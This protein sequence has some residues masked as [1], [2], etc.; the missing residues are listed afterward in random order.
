MGSEEA[1]ILRDLKRAISEYVGLGVAFTLVLGD[2]TLQAELDDRSLLE[3]GL[4]EG[5]TLVVLMQQRIHVVTASDGTTA[6]SG[7]QPPSSWDRRNLIMGG[8]Q[9]SIDCA[10]RTPLV[11]APPPPSSSLSYFNLSHEKDGIT[12][13]RYRFKCA[14]MRSPA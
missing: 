14:E 5:T 2:R 1:K 13:G 12:R 9:T 6:R 4:E 8:A 10:L 3:R 11:Q 7:A